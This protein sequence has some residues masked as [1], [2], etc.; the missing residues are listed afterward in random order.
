MMCSITLGATYAT[1]VGRGF[2]GAWLNTDV[3][4]GACLCLVPGPLTGAVF[5]GYLLHLLAP[6]IFLRGRD[7]GA[8]DSHLR[9]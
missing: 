5:R 1:A 6:L 9:T 3:S 7:V 2:A 8:Q 4:G